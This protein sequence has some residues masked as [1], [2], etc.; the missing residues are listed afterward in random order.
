MKEL[1]QY[2]NDRYDDKN[3]ELQRITAEDSRDR[4]LTPPQKLALIDYFNLC[5][6]ESVFR[7]AGYI[8]DPV[9]ESWENGMRQFSKDPRIAEL[10]EE[11][12]KTN[13]YYGFKLPLG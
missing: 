13:S 11:E 6:E 3:D 10:W 1:F 2:F 8:Y 4:D 9:W 12:Q 5:D 7:D